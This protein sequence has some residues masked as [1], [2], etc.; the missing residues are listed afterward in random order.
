MATGAD[1]IL[2]FVLPSA[3]PKRRLVNLCQSRVRV[4]RRVIAT[5]TDERFLPLN[6]HPK[7]GVG[8]CD[9]HTYP[10]H[11]RSLCK[12]FPDGSLICHSFVGPSLGTRYIPELWWGSRDPFVSFTSGKS[13]NVRLSLLPI[14]PLP[15]IRLNNS[16]DSLI[17][18]SIRQTRSTSGSGFLHR[19]PKSGRR[20]RSTCSHQEGRGID[21]DLG[22]RGGRHRRPSTTIVERPNQNSTAKVNHGGFKNKGKHISYQERP[23]QSEPVGGTYRPDLALDPVRR[24][25]SGIHA[26]VG[27][28]QLDRGGSP[29]NVPPL[30]STVRYAVRDAGMSR[31]QMRRVSTRISYEVKRLERAYTTALP[32]VG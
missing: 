6:C 25:G 16:E 8:R 18:P 29:L 27:T 32:S 23:Y 20:S 4:W 26:K 1:A 31:E 7:R 9:Y 15:L 24:V 2:L 13:I 22:R 30:S 5:N 10:S 21:L 12:D 11:S 17:T 28:G 14:S 19:K 3:A